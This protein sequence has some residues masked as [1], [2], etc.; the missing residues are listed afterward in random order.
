VLKEAL[1]DMD[2]VRCNTECTGFTQDE[3]GVTAKFADGSTDR[4]AALIGADGVRSVIREQTVGDGPPTYSTMTA[5][6]GMPAYRHPRLPPNISQQVYGPEAIFGMFPCKERLFWWASEVRPEGQGDPPGGRKADLLGTFG[7][8]P[9]S[10]RT[11][12]EST[13]EEQIFRGDL[14]HRIPIKTWTQGLVTLLGDAAH[15]TMPAFGQGAGMAIED[16]AVLARE[17]NAGGG[18]DR[19]SIATAFQR[20]EARR[21]PRTKAIVDRARMMAKMCTWKSTPAVLTREAMLTA[22]PQKVWLNTY[23]HEHT[24]Q[25]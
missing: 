16:A 6:R 3:N 1:G 11:V 8:W 24:Y 17:I 18:L 15:P 21:V 19:A 13:P 7:S 12:I 20:Y 14:Y 25:L 22:V 10:I 5:W 2:L 23:E 4:G 9:E